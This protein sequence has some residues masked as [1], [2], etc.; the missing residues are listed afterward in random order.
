VSENSL[1]G[2]A[3]SPE[4]AATDAD[5]G[6]VDTLKYKITS[7]YGLAKAFEISG[8]ETKTAPVLVSADGVG[9]LNFEKAAEWNIKVQVQD[10]NALLSDEVQVT[11]N[12]T[13]ANDPPVLAD[14]SLSVVENTPAGA[15]VAPAAVVKSDPFLVDPCVDAAGEPVVGRLCVYEEDTLAKWGMAGGSYAA[16]LV[17]GK[18]WFAFDVA[19]GAMSVKAGAAVDYEAFAKGEAKQCKYEVTVTDAGGATGKGVVTINIGN[20]H[21]PPVIGESQVVTIKESSAVATSAPAL[22]YTDQDANT[23]VTWTLLSGGGGD[24]TIPD[25]SGSGTI[26]ALV[27]LDYE[28]KAQ[29]KVMVMVKDNTGLFNVTEVTVDVEDVNDAPVIGSFS[30]NCTE[31]LAQKFAPSFYDAVADAAAAGGAGGSAKLVGAIPE[32]T[33]EDEVHTPQGLTYTLGGDLTKYFEIKLVSVR[34]HPAV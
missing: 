30:L 23:F 33:D 29:Y 11:I 12:I 4:L 6:D 7:Y 34:S 16:S 3:A 28:T 32:A 8:A 2:I 17:S 31:N 13:N 14:L 20:E 22:T 5:V 21:E 9:A 24:L 1:A 25:Q 26:N 27:P 19:T 10:S 15:A 18:D